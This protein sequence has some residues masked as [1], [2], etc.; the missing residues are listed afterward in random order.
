MNRIYYFCVSIPLNNKMPP[1]FP[2]K[3]YLY[4]IL[5]I[6]TV[7]IWGTTF[8]STKVL[9]E[10]GLSP[11]EIL[12]YRF[13]LAYIVIWFV[14]PRTFFSKSIRDELLFIG[15]GLCAGSLYFI[16]ENTALQIT[17]ASNVSLIVCTA[18]LFTAFLSH[19]IYRNDKIKPNLILGSVVAFLGVALVVFNGSFMLKINPLGDF[20]TILAALSWAFY[21]IIL[22]K[23]NSRYATTFITRKVFFYGIITVL[24]YIAL[25]PDTIHIHLL[26]NPIIIVNLVF[27]GIVASMLCYIMWNSAVKELGVVQAS[28]YIYF[29]PLVTLI[30][31]AI[32]INEHITVIALIGSIFILSGIYVAEKGFKFKFK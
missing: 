32:V 4:H 23:L 11:A 29:I 20:L 13:L 22:R 27:L 6:V 25:K 7:I 30:T 17:L 8:V 26:G 19:L 14:C 18:P 1:M 12:L 2:L 3:P 10:H 28:N 21:G 24:P 16:F 15:S 9:I 31:S 5:A